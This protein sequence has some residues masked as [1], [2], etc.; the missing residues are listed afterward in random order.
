[1]KTIILSLLVLFGS[2]LIMAQEAAPQTS[3]A[4]TTASKKKKTAAKKPIEKTAVAAPATEK[5]QS[6]NQG[7]QEWLTRMKKRVSAA[8]SKQNK[9]GAVAAVRGDEKSDPPPLYWKGKEGEKAVDSAE[10]E[11]FNAAVEMAL[12]GDADAAKQKLQQFVNA[13]PQSPLLPD[14]NETLAKLSTTEPEQEPAP[15]AATE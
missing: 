14:A 15:T 12:K 11:E 10:I 1:M 8:R 3:P 9:L 6:M 13:H 5:K 2:S 7:L 4:K